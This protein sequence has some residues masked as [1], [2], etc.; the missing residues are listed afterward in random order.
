MERFHTVSEAVERF[1]HKNDGPHEIGETLQERPKEKVKVEKRK[2]LEGRR[3]QLG[4]VSPKNSEEEMVVP[5]NIA[6]LSA[7]TSLLEVR[8]PKNSEE[9][10]VPHKIADLV[11]KIAKTEA[12]Y[13]EESTSCKAV[14]EARKKQA[15][16]MAES[17][18]KKAEEDA[19]KSK[20]EEEAKK[21][22]ADEEEAARKIDED[23]RR[24][25]AI[26]KKKDARKRKAKAEARKK[27]TEEEEAARKIDEA[28]RREEEASRKKAEE[29]ARKRKAEEEARKKMAGEEARK[30][31]NIQRG[32]AKKPAASEAKPDTYRQNPAASEAKL[33]ADAAV[34]AEADA[35]VTAESPAEDDEVARKIDE[36]AQMSSKQRGIT[37]S[38]VFDVAK[39][40]ATQVANAAEVISNFYDAWGVKRSS[41]DIACLSM[42]FLQVCNS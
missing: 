5:R 1:W 9:E 40:R 35:A 18:R 2:G 7:E 11:L 36:A 29:D 39:A 21:K 37:L 22:K 10:V 31:A 12:S 15:E 14:E 16:E 41:E 23:F 30:K 27:K 34:T 33:E 17:S 32:S 6:D 26:R 19:R 28:F 4:A 38:P 24:E 25:E 42:Q 20:S 8:S 13:E 3:M